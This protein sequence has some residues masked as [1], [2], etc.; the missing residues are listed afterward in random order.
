MK[1]I[2]IAASAILAL[3][4][5]VAIQSGHSSGQNSFACGGCTNVV[6]GNA[7]ACGETNNAFSGTLAC[8]ETNAAIWACGETNSVAGGA[9]ACGETNNLFGGI[10]ACG[11][12]TNVVSGNLLALR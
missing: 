3:T 11:G 9:L 4:V 8:G 10:L 6:P 1:R 5:L 12:C 7:L 2:I